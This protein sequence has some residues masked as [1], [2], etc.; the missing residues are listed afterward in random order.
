MASEGILVLIPGLKAAADLSAKQFHAVKLTGD[1][2]V[3]FS[4][5]GD[6]SVGILQNDP[7][8]VGEASSVACAGVSKAK[9]GATISAAG[10][11]LAANVA[12]LLVPAASGD[13]VIGVSLAPA[14]T[15]DVFEMLLQLGDEIA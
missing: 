14:A 13:F 6:L 3:N 1:H 5:A 10:L 9:C 4:G 7:K 11:R 12:G 8:V 2:I 15:N